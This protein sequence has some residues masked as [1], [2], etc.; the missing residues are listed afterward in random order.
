MGLTVCPAA[1]VNAPVETVWELLTDPA[2]RDTWWDTRTDHVEPPGKAQAGQVIC[3]KNS[4]LGREMRATLTVER[5]DAAKHQIEWVLHSALTNHQVT[6]VAVL[7]A[8]SCRV[9][10]G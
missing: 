4:K 6:T 8:H 2:L 3:L 1:V 10:Y 7:D 5:V 9:Q